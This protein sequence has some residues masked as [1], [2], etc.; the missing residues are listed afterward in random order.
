MSAAIPAHPA[1][2]RRPGAPLIALVS[3]ALFG[4]VQTLGAQRTGLLRFDGSRS[5]WW[6]VELSTLTWLSAVSVVVGVLVAARLGRAA[7]GRTDLFSVGGAA[8]GSLAT[9][10]LISVNAA[11]AAV[12]STN[13]PT[14]GTVTHVV[15]GVV[16]GS[17]A[18]LLAQRYRP[19]AVGL[20]TGSAL[21]WALALLSALVLPDQAP[22]LGHPYLGMDSV[23]AQRIAALAVAAGY[24][25]L[26]AVVWRRASVEARITAAVAA[27]TL[28]ALAYLSTAVATSASWPWS[29][30]P[31]ALAAIPC[32]ALGAAVGVALRRDQR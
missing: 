11:W 30:V 13:A 4:I 31:S 26:L 25:L 8:L 32:A 29:P 3:G 20:A 2:G 5:G 21:L 14:S 24:G 10:P 27:P 6:A 7:P 28:L 19:V 16:L 17:L 12:Y 23:M 18:G 1:G 9:A 22:V 15:L